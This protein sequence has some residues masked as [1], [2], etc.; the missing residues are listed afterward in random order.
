MLILGAH[1]SKSKYG[2]LATIAQILTLGGQAISIFLGSPQKLEMITINPDE[3]DTIAKYVK[4][5]KIYL[6][7][8][9]K[10]LYNLA[11][12]YDGKYK[13]MIKCYINEMN[14]IH[15]MGGRGSVIHFG[16]SVGLEPSEAVLNTVTNI[17]IILKKA[18]PGTDIILETS[19]GQGSEMF[20]K[21]PEIGLLWSQFT[22]AEKKRIKFCIDTCHIF[23][24]GYDIRTRAG[25]INYLEEWKK[26]KI[27]LNHFALIHFNDSATSLGSNRD[28]HAAFGTGYI[29]DI[30]KGGSWVGI[31]FL[32]K[33]CQR[34]SIPLILE[35]EGGKYHEKLGA[36]LQEIKHHLPNLN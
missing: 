22:A 21:V 4:A 23:A 28:R 18:N 5:N 16:K 13:Y 17:K 9:A 32:I 14:L 2:Y 20:T 26:A 10:Y 19:S 7:A 6:F 35:R 33:F 11:K 36:E 24:A 3:S 15:Q 12:P 34:K 29:T 31:K 1:L 27:G 8:H 30:H 25:V